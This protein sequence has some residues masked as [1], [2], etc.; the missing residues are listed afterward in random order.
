[1]TPKWVAESAPLRS[2][3]RSLVTAPPNLAQLQ[4]WTRGSIP[5]SARSAANVASSHSFQE[6]TNDNGDLC[7]VMS[8][9]NR[10]LAEHVAS[11]R[12]PAAVRARVAVR[13]ELRESN[14]PRGMQDAAV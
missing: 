9:A 3:L 6:W 8:G 14:V 11:L 5:S 10:P 2:R 7:V 4:R 13:A 12:K 1:M